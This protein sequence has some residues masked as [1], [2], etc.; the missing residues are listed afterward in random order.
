MLDHDTGLDDEMGYRLHLV[1][2]SVPS[3]MAHDWLM[4][5][6]P[7]RIVQAFLEH[8]AMVAF[9]AELKHA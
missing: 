3:E 9:A 5:P 1:A 8:S 2:D 6:G 7:G 4:S